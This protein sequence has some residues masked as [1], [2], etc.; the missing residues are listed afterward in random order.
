MKEKEAKNTEIIESTNDVE[1][2]N[3]WRKKHGFPAIGVAFTE[4]ADWGKVIEERN[5][6]K[7][8]FKGKEV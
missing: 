2:V 8:K 1:M 3:E 7:N 5:N 4:S 6:N